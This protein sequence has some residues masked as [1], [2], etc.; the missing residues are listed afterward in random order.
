M[1]K[2]F[3]QT[4]FVIASGDLMR[5]TDTDFYVKTQKHCKLHSTCIGTLDGLTITTDRPKLRVNVS[6]A[7][8]V[9]YIVLHPHAI[10]TYCHT[11]KLVTCA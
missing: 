7:N 11:T 5:H 10:M 9:S 8:N 6:S 4:N 2:N 3:V 1:S